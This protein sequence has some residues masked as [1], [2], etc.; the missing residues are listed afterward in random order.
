MALNTLKCNH[1]MPLTFKGLKPIFSQSVFLHSH[2]SLAHADLLISWNLTTRCLAVTGSGGGDKC[3]RLSEP[4]W[5][6]ISVGSESCPIVWNNATGSFKVTQGHRFWYQSK[7]RVRLP[8]A[9]YTNFYHVSHRFRAL[10]AYCSNYRFGQGVPLFNTLVWGELLNS[11]LRNLALKQEK[12]HHPIMY[13]V[14][15]ATSCV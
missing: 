14:T 8:I 2:L 1:L 6:W 11:G 7:A 4:R 12:T 13:R 9:E 3:G 15:I 10:A 5:F